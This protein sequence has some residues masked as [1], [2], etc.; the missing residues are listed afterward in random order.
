MAASIDNFQ[1]ELK[2]LETLIVVSHKLYTQ[3]EFNL[4]TLEA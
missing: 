2:P 4:M 1:K 3:E